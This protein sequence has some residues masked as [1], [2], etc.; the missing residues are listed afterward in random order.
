MKFGI[1][2][3]HL[4]G[5]LE[6]LRR[7][8]QFA[9]THAFDWFS[10]SDH[11]QETPG[12]GGGLPCFESLAMLTA[13][14]LETKRIRVGCLVFCVSYR[15]P[16]VLAKALS[17]IDALSSGRVTCGLGAGW[18]EPE[19]RAYGI[20]FPTAG[21]RED[22]LEEYAHVLRVLFDEPFADFVGAHYTLDHAPNFPKPLQPRLPIWIGGGGEK[23][24]LRTTAKYADGW[25]VP[26][27]SAAEWTAKNAVLDRWCD[28][29][30]RDPGAIARTVN[31][32]FYMGADP[33]G[34]ARAANRFT[35]EW[36]ANERRTGFVRG[37]AREAAETVATYR[38]AGVEQLNIALR[39]GPY[40]WDAL[41]AFA[42]E[43]VPEFASA[44]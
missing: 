6:E 22:Q 5:P 23:R 27:L 44:R 16:I 28:R 34:A 14:A 25:N 41:A 4:G 21:V 29:V 31:V 18:H 7:L 12:Q 43:I 11:F 19:Y 40:D 39:A 37:T 8:W 42:E 26:Y 33:A 13:A 10:V 35:A 30:G 15:H 2:V 3:G 17:A 38:D 9:D 1:Q 36:G 24:T 20:P 32:G